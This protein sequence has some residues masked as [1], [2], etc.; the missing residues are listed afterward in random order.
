MR[1]TDELA[2]ALRNLPDDSDMIEPDDREGGLRLTC[3]AGRV[4]QVWHGDDRIEHE[5]DCWFARLVAAA[6][7]AAE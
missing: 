6:R 3:C 5:K 1:M 4:V 7:G 2:V